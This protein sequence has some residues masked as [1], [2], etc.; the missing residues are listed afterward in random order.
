[1]PPACWPSSSAS[2]R[3]F[4]PDPKGQVSPPVAVAINERLPWFSFYRFHRAHHFRP[5][6]LLAELPTAL[7]FAEIAVRARIAFTNRSL[8]RIADHLRVDQ[9]SSGWP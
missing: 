7:R 9:I 5:R 3:P 1:M 8:P 6:H 2:C 4:L